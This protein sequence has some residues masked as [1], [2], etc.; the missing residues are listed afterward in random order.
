[1]F[2]RYIV[3]K[4]NRMRRLLI[5]VDYQNDLVNGILGFPEA[6]SLE[7][8]ICV[9]VKKR[10]REGSDVVFTRTMHDKN[11]APSDGDCPY[12][13]SGSGGEEF[14]GGVKKLAS[15]HVIFERN[16]FGESRLASYIKNHQYDEIELC[17]IDHSSNV[18]ATAIIAKDN[19]PGA[20][21]RLLC[22][23]SGSRDPDACEANQKEAKRL[24][25][26][27]VH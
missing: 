27:V 10:E 23:L 15:R 26:E 7:E 21:I 12:C 6:E 3:Q 9:H 4:E 14:Y 11:F 25:M 22:S 16:A 19:C 1:M 24:G 18:L 17:G 5:V 20:S 2:S 13:V 8:K